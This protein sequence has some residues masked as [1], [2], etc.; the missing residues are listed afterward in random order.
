M[1]DNQE[2]PSGF[3]PGLVDAANRMRDAVN[4]HVVAG[5][6]GVRERH[7][8]W[9]AIRLEDGRSDGTVYESRRDAV[10]HT[11][12]KTRGWFYVKVGVDSMSEKQA[13]IVLQMARQA[14]KNGIVF[15]EEEPIVPM[16]TELAQPYIPNTLSRLS[17]PTRRNQ[18]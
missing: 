14:Y 13:I 4:L 18:R 6:L 17:L 7:L 12:N 1:P 3:A 9:L 16:L 2:A 10:R 5:A 15:A 11:Q 8:Q